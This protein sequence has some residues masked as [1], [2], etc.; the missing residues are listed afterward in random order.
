MDSIGRYA[1]RRLSVDVANLTT[2]LAVRVAGIEL[3]TEMVA[4]LTPESW[5]HQP[6]KDED[7]HIVVPLELRPPEECYEVAIPG[8]QAEVLIRILSLIRELM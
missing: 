4:Q 8:G 2:E 1:V 6:L 7:G 5:E 3:L